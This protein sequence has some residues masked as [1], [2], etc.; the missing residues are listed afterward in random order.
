MKHLAALLLIALLAACN[1]T[2]QPVAVAPTSTATLEL[3]ATSALPPSVTPLTVGSKPT[4]APPPLAN[5]TLPPGSLCQVYTTYSGS[6]PDNLLSLR[7]APT[8]SARQVLKLPNKASVF[9]VPDSQEI[10]A[11][12][13]HWLNIIYVDTSN[14][15]FQG[16]TARDSFEADGIRNPLIATLRTASQ[17]APC[18]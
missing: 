18:Q 2:T 11:D 4:L 14:Q 3:T 9:L 15:R 16:W 17:Q 1:L 12:G 8:V 6:D 13:Y 5:A 10:E 7:A